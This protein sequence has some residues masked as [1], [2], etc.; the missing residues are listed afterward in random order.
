M[1]T[2]TRSCRPA[3]LTILA[4]GVACNVHSGA[5]GRDGGVTGNTAG[6]RPVVGIC[7]YGCIWRTVAHEVRDG[8]KET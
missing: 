5:N 4:M 1:I 3:L 6:I 8:R 7:R 2:Q